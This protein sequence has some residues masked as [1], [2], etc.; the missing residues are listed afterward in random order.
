MNEKIFVSHACI[1]FITSQGDYHAR[2]DLRSHETGDVIFCLDGW[3]SIHVVTEE[4]AAAET[5]GK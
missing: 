5:V 2:V 1:F 4:E 3:V